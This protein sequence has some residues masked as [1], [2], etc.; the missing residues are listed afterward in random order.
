MAVRGQ[1]GLARP[2]PP[3]WD[4][5]AAPAARL[6]H[7]GVGHHGRQVD[8]VAEAG[9]LDHEG[10]EAELALLVGAQLGL[11]GQEVV[12][13]ED[14]FGLG[15]GTVELDIAE[16]SLGLVTALLDAAGQL[17]LAAPQGQGL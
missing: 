10:V 12:H 11:E 5:G 7:A 13:G 14:C 2:F 1:H 3:A 9:P 16:R 6:A 17:G 4:R 8:V 15:V